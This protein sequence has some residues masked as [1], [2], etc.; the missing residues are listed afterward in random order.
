M[1]KR[2][3]TEKFAS[4]G[5]KDCWHPYSLQ[6]LTPSKFTAV[7]GQIM[8]GRYMLLSSRFSRGVPQGRTY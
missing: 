1:P 7:V 2:K 4:S 6:V 5:E 8:Q 3:Q